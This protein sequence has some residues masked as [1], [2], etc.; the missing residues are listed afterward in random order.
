MGV[1][2]IKNNKRFFNKADTFK[3]I[4]ETSLYLLFT[5]PYV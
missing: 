2:G 4:E 1:E 3:F 5:V